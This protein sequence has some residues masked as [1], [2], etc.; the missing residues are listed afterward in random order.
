MKLKVLSYNI[1]KGMN[2]GNREFILNKI[3]ESIRQVTPD[4]VFLQEVVGD[5]RHH[6]MRIEEWPTNAQFEFLA[7]ETW[8]HFAYGKNAVY[9]QGHHGNAILSKYPILH[10]DNTDLTI[11]TYEY[12][13]LTHG[14]I[15]IPQTKKKLDLF[16]THLNL[17]HGSR[18]MQLET[19][20]QTIK[21][22]TSDDSQLILAGDFNDWRNRLGGRLLEELHLKEAFTC[23]RGKPA[24][25]FPGHWPFLRL[26]RIYFRGMS[27]I[28]GMVMET[29]RWGKLSDHLPLSATFEIT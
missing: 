16:C 29:G 11:N 21:N 5:H 3:R 24:K 8:P 2:I 26:D 6:K 17:L 15:E 14:Q 7:D 13:G 19:I 4:I 23:L 25:T 28:D 1:H 12:R 22:K 18:V 20:I 9:E 27:V 10:W